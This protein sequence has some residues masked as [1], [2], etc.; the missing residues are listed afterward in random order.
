M[1]I[2]VF[3]VG[4]PDLSVETLPIRLKHHGYHGIEWRIASR[5]QTPPEPLP[6]RNQWYWTY[7]QATLNLDQIHKEAVRAK[8]LSDQAG[9]EI[10]S[11]STY[12]GPG[13]KNEI[14]K[15]MQAAQAI[16]C[17]RIRVMPP[18]YHGEANYPQLFA[19]VQTQIGDLVPLTEKYGV[20]IILEIHHGNVIPS[21]SAA[22]RL[23]SPFPSKSVGII[24]DPGNMVHE[25]FEQYQLG[26]ELLGEY[27]EHV[28]I[29]DA[30]PVYDAEHKKWSIE[31]CSIGEGM[32]DFSRLISA[33]R[34]V[35]YAGYLS[36]EDFSC[37]RDT[38]GKLAHNIS[39]LQELLHT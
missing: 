20:K 2:A 24:F 21:A 28:H 12:L 38:E 32:V 6:P 18:G 39:Y 26:L 25:G 4:T 31:W 3:T 33:L 23:V 15:V 9:L 30:R 8:S 1:K 19:A 35:G 7:N 10:V 34:S 36:T 16:G 17:P 11:L 13:Q 22:Y 37:D 14:E 29:K 27:L 5:P